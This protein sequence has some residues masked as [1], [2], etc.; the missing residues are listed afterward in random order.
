MV[1]M[2]RRRGEECEIWGLAVGDKGWRGCAAGGEEWGRLIC[3]FWVWRCG[4]VDG[5]S[6]TK[7][8]VGE[9]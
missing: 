2:K 6:E 1:S 8:R 7:R 3:L 9:G 5:E 4:A